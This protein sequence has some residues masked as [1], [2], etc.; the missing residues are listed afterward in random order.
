MSKIAR[1]G[2]DKKDRTWYYSRGKCVIIQKEAGAMKRIFILSSHPLFGQGV[3]NLLRQE[4]RLE[5]VGREA[6]VDN[7]I[8]RIKKLQPDVVIVDSSDPASDPTSAV[9]RILREGVGTK[10]IGLNLQDNTICIYRGEQ[11]VVKEVKDLVEAIEHSPL[12]PEPL[13]SED[14]TGLG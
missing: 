2:V 9:M 8:R 11:R 3:E 12:S 1:I 4:S 14:L 13:S 10:V 7:A 5:I 6:D